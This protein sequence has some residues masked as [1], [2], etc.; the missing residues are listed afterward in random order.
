M[1]SFYY[2]DR[3]DVNLEDVV[4][5]ENVAKQIEDFLLE[6]QFKEKL[7]SYQL[8]IANKILMYG[9]TGC[10][11]TMTAK[12]VAKHLN[13]K[14]VI[15]NLATIISSKLGETAKNIDALFKEAQ[16]EGLVLFFDEFDSLGQIRD[17]DN[18][19]NSEM[20]RVVNAILQLIDNFPQKSI[21]MA[22]TNQVQMIDEAL[23]RRFE[24]HLEFTNPTN[25]T[26][27]L[28]YDKLL[29]NFPKEYCEINR[30]YNTSFA[31]AKNLALYQ[32]KKNIIQSEIKNQIVAN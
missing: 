8:P 32:V 25:E 14:L 2:I 15:V 7:L 27:D 19:D 9:A 22:A 4:F 6:Q 28:Y 17:Y 20:K 21:L 11:K 16:Y 12:A 29:A 3:S 23:K 30:T 13:K 26:L 1:S 24:M 10:G 18:K 5:N 31:E